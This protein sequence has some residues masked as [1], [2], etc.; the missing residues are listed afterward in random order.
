[1]ATRYCEFFQNIRFGFPI[2][3]IDSGYATNKSVDNDNNYVVFLVKF[4]LR[5]QG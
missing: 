3:F 2:I 1:M 5:S 4:I